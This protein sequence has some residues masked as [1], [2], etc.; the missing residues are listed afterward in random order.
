MNL[1]VVDDIAANRKL[2]RVQLEAENHTV[3]EAAD[4]IAA[5]ALLEREPVDAIISDILMP[6]MDGYRLC[7]EVRKSPTL[8]HLRFLLYSS[9]YTSPT[10][11]RL[12]ETVGADQ[13][14]A[15]PAPIAVILGALR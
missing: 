10:D 11:V 4:G 9:T 2:L 6:R 3:L 8:R 13:F 12:S 15:K 7:H 5:L 1:L 14:I